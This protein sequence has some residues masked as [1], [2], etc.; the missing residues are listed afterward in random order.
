LCDEWWCIC[1]PLVTHVL[2]VSPSSSSPG[3]CH[4]SPHPSQPRLVRGGASGGASGSQHVFCVSCR[5]FWYHP[6]THLGRSHA[7]GAR[8]HPAPLVPSPYLLNA[9]VSKDR[10]KIKIKNFTI[11]RPQ[12][13]L[14]TGPGL[15]VRCVVVEVTW[16]AHLQCAFLSSP[17]LA[18]LAL[19]VFGPGYVS[20]SP[21]PFSTAWSG[22]A[23]PAPRSMLVASTSPGLAQPRL[24]LT[25]GGRVGQVWGMHGASTMVVDQEG[26][27]GPGPGVW[28][29]FF[30]QG[31]SFNGQKKN[32]QGFCCTTQLPSLKPGLKPC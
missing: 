10:I 26:V 15:P 32:K 4:P 9:V 7:W 3:R 12:H 22:R 20:C 25:Q 14:G 8:C 21:D 29:Q 13:L 6:A 28:S 1:A 2:H 31:N 11:G 27:A 17:G 16:P 23:F 18:R 30:P 19:H 24:H 5:A